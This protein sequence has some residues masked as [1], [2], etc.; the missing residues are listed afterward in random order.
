METE[1]GTQLHFTHGNK[2]DHRNIRL[3]WCFLELKPDFFETLK[4]MGTLPTT[5]A[6]GLIEIQR[7][8]NYWKEL[9]RKK[10]EAGPDP[11]ELELAA[12]KRLL[13]EQREE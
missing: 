8:F 10:I 3:E 5:S 6:K 4:L 2:I 9:E 1:F 12:T 7:E 11:L 13:D